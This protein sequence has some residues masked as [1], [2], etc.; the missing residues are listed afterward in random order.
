MLNHS[1]VLPK[2]GGFYSHILDLRPHFPDS[3][4]DLNF[5]LGFFV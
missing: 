4:L 1:E 2:K 3:G 5:P